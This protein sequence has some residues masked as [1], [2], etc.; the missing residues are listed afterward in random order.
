M[1]RRQRRSG[2]PKYKM[3]LGAPVR[4]YEG[5]PAEIRARLPVF[6]RRPFLVVPTGGRA[7][8]VNP[9]YDTIVRLPL[10]GEPEVGVGL[11]SRTYTLIQHRDLLEMLIQ[12]LAAAGVAPDE[13]H[14]A[15]QITEFG[16]RME[17]QLLLPPRYSFDPG[18]SKPMALEVRC[19][20]SVDASTSLM[21]LVGW[22][23][24]IC[25]NGL[26]VG[27]T[28]VHVDESHDARLRFE[29]IE[30]AIRS[31][32]AAAVA[33]REK[34]REW[35][36]QE[37]SPDELQ[38]WVDGPLK[39]RWGVK[40]AT[41]AYHILTTGDDVDLTRPFEKGPPS[42]K[43]VAVRRSVPGAAVPGNN[44]FAVSQALAWI[45]K[46]SSTVQD[47]IERMM[48]VPATVDDLVAELRARK[49]SAVPAR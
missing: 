12:A 18:D 20:N 26:V 44:A 41:R 39:Q 37:I 14:A 2:Q 7:A 28:R 13:V 15:V 49:R 34:Y 6:E 45:A 33:E 19:I 47:Q 24:F 17:L 35:V 43:T 10:D 23:R 9:L 16:E 11:V 38:R 8:Q 3:W 22:F 1:T 42:R 40:A 31:G 36:A 32:I 27:D 29:D 4:R 5:T 46:E 25:S 21:L 30:G 48:K